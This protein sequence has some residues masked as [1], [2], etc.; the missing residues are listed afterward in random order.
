MDNKKLEM[1]L[2]K[3]V[4]F[5]KDLQKRYP[6]AE[7]NDI[8]DLVLSLRLKNKEEKHVFPSS[9]MYN[10]VEAIQKNIEYGVYDLN[11]Y[12]DHTIK[13]IKD[14]IIS[15]LVELCFQM[16][17]SN[18]KYK[19]KIEDYLAVMEQTLDF[20]FPLNDY[21]MDIDIETWI[22][23]DIPKEH[24]ETMH[25]LLYDINNS[26]YNRSV[27]AQKIGDYTKKILNIK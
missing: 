9:Y 18:E 10:E 12:V 22:W 23:K 3:I 25:D 6:N 20:N 14:K 19:D 17:K 1:F 11:V 2:T 21:S 7:V 16:K 4:N 27:N 13:T 15:K 26:N 5:K 24:F 8:V